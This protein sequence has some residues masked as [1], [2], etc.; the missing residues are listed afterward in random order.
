MRDAW[1]RAHAGWPRAYPLVQFPNAPL[2]AAFAAWVAA[3]ATDGAVSDYARG[4]FLTGVAAWAW[5]EL[6]DGA[7]AVRRMMGAG[8]LVYVAAQIGVALGG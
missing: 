8:G 6:T 7:N 5:L 3:A 1:R 2:L 4:A